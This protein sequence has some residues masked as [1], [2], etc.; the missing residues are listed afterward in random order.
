MGLTLAIASE[1]RVGVVIAAWSG[2]LSRMY[3]WDVERDVFTPGQFVK[4]RASVLAISPNGKYV[5][6]YAEAFSKVDQAYVAISHVPYFTAQVFQS[7]FHLGSRAARFAEDGSLD[8]FVMTYSFPWV[9]NRESVQDRID[10]GC[11][12]EIRLHGRRDWV[13][14]RMAPKNAD[15]RCTEDQPRNRTVYSGGLDLVERQPRDKEPRVLK[16]FIKE[17]FQEVA[18]PEWA[19]RW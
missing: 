6:Y 5:V 13:L 4:A 8:L 14:N 17:E 3:H 19:T 9:R 10:K 18:P 7:Q 15:T 2:R 11:P 1:A 16:S 12:F